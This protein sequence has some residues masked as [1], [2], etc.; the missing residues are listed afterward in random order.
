ME[1]ANPISQSAAEKAQDRGS[2][3]GKRRSYVASIS[4][5]VQ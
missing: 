4:P 2:H 3:V 5:T 1:Q